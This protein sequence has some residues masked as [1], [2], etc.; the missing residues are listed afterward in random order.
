MP[1]TR[2]IS[3]RRM[4]QPFSAR[5]PSVDGSPASHSDQP[6]PD[7]RASPPDRLQNHDMAIAARS[8][9]TLFGLLN[10]I[11]VTGGGVHPY[12]V[13][14]EGVADEAS[15]DW[16]HGG[17]NRIC[18]R[19]LGAFPRLRRSRHNGRALP[20]SLQRTDPEGCESSGADKPLG[21]RTACRA[22]TPSAA[23]AKC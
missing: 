16:H 9:Q 6:R 3:H 23:R 18:N 20:L 4:C 7:R 14:A 13:V 15:I 5:R 12:P 22:R 10:A 21:T 2:R 17:H 1:K 19:R 8:Q 11:E